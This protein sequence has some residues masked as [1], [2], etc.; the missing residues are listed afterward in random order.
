MISTQYKFPFINS[1]EKRINVS[2]ELLNFQQMDIEKLF[3]MNFE[4]LDYL[5]SLPPAKLK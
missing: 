4:V 5:K 1:K 2:A 3:E